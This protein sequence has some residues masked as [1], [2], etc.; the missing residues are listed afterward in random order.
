ML[1]KLA[2]ALVLALLSAVC[3][4]AGGMGKEVTAK[5]TW[6]PMGMRKSWVRDWICPAFALITLF[7]FFKP[8]VWWGYLLAIPV[9]GLNGGAFSTYWDWA[10]GGND[11]YY[12]HGFFVGLSFFPFCFVGMPWWMLVIQV[13]G[14]SVSMG[15]WSAKTD[16]DYL[17]EY[18]RGFFSSIFRV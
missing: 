6:M 14:I 4:R 16:K 15:L 9:Y 5:P 10:F 12:A 1:I 3:Y 17:E 2:I 11:N 8:T 18:G 13:V 7:L